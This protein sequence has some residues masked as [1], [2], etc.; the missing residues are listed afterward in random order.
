MKI[1]DVSMESYRW[2]RKKPIRNGRYVYPTAGLDVVKIETDD[3]PIGLGLSG[4]VEQA[5]GIGREILSHLKQYVIGQ[6][7]FDTERIWEEM[8]QPKL[9]GRRGVTTRV[10]SGIDIALWDLKGKITG[11]PVYK[12]LGGYAEKIPVYI[13]GGYY[14]EDKGLDELAKE[15]EI[16]LSVGA[17]AVKMKIG[18]VTIKEDV[19]RVRVVRDTIGPDVKLMV[20]AN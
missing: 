2:P 11:Q 14:E 1:T 5:V 8:W 7:P 3:G 15:M 10:I 18:G 20:D 13:A 17:S 12:L 6:D 4:G 9:G 16:A 19:E